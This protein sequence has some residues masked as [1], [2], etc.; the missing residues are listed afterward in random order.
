MVMRMVVIRRFQ[1]REEDS[2][3]MGCCG[4][5]SLASVI[6]GNLRDRPCVEER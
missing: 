6:G 4:M 1:S 3:R 5:F 2:K